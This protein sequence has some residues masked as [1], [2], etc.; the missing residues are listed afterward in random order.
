MHQAACRRF[1]ML[2]ALYYALTHYD[3]SNLLRGRRICA[4]IYTQTHF[5]HCRIERACMHTNFGTATAAHTHGCACKFTVRPQSR[6]R[7]GRLRRT[8]GAPLKPL[9]H[10][11]DQHATVAKNPSQARA[12][13]RVF[14]TQHIYEHICDYASDLRG[15]RIRYERTLYALMCSAGRYAVVAT[16]QQPPD[17][18]HTHTH[19]FIRCGHYRRFV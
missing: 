13:Q 4:L 7:A 16:G 19:M 6:A 14:Y 3:A 2:R 1:L 11:P 9:T 17:A 15:T 8:T 18:S 10:R 5:M 12:M